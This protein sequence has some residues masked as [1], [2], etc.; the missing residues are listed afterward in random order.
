MV[1][2][3]GD[4]GADAMTQGKPPFRSFL[5]EVNC[6]LLDG[7]TTAAVTGFGVHSHT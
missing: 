1:R 4:S 5:G 2:L 7:E 6:E 3:W